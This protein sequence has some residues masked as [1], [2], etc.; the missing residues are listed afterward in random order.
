MEGEIAQFCRTRLQKQSLTW[1][2]FLLLFAYW[3]PKFFFSRTIISLLVFNRKALIS[4]CTFTINRLETF[5]KNPSLPTSSK[6]GETKKTPTNK[7][8]K[9]KGKNKPSPT[10][11]TLCWHEHNHKKGCNSVQCLSASL[12]CAFL[13]AAAS[14]TQTQQPWWPSTHFN[15]I[16]NTLN[17]EWR[18]RSG[19]HAQSTWRALRKEP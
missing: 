6:T 11:P 8:P 12:A 13:P 2:E 15:A 10:S 7:K 14:H 18:M 17:K 5:F 3:F 1:W 19:S 4:W 9:T 16:N